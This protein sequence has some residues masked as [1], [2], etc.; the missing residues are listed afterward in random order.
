MNCVLDSTAAQGRITGAR[1]NIWQLAIILSKVETWPYYVSALAVELTKGEQEHIVIK[2]TNN[3]EAYDAFLKGQEHYLRLVPE[4]FAK[5]IRYYEKATELDPNYSRAYA[6][7][8]QAYWV[9]SGM[10]LH[11]IKDFG[12]PWDEQRLR[13]SYYLEKAMEKPT[14]IAHAIA[15]DM[16]LYMRQHEEAIAEAE[17]AV[18]LDPNAPESLHAMSKALIFGGRPEEAIILLKRAMRLDPRSV[19]MSLFELG[20]AQLYMGQLEEAA[21]FLKR[22]VTH[23]PETR[24][25]WQLLAVAYALSGREEEA[26]AMLKK[27]PG[28]PDLK[29]LMNFL[30]FR[31]MEIADRF[32]DGLIKAGLPGKPSGYYK[33]YKE[34]QLSEEEIKKTFL[35]RS[36]TGFDDQEWSIACNKDGKAAF[37]YGDTYYNGKWW[38]DNNSFCVQFKNVM[39]GLKDCS[40]LYSNPEGTSE[41]KS[42]YLM[43]NYY[44]L[45]PFSMADWRYY[46]I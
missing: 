44:G 36:M 17:R 32:A 19:G 15:S 28:A 24:S 4:D 13:A 5:A 1:L 7:L 2:G 43:M 35:G 45:F 38:L 10:G 31:D 16:L 3:I 25:F 37:R 14:T 30:P 6:A 26:R 27:Y 12:V 22:S 11:R 39:G 18:A 34:H 33:V 21:D 41:K 29:G 42:E 20:F 23:N 8:A 9:G 40:Y 46:Q